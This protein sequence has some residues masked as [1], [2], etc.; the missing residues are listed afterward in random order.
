MD[1]STQS[2]PNNSPGCIDVPNRSHLW[3]IFQHRVT[4]VIFNLTLAI[5]GASEPADWARV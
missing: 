1:A 3:V 2:S 5:E 4:T